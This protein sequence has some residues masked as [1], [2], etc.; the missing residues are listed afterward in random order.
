MKISDVT[1]YLP[2]FFMARDRISAPWE[3][4]GALMRQLNQLY[5]G[6]NVVT[7][8]GFKIHLESDE[9]VHIG[10]N[11]NTPHVEVSAE[12]GNTERASQLVVEYT[13]QLR[14]IIDS[15]GLHDN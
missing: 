7:T 2:H 9:W 5:R 14:S 12:A 10:L 15:I 13:D 3:I 8:D 4:K 6:E 1:S 11:P